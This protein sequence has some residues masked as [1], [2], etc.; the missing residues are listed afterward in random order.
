VLGAAAALASAPTQAQQWLTDV[1]AGVLSNSNLGNAVAGPDVHADTALTAALSTGPFFELRPGTNLI[2]TAETGAQSFGRYT[3]FSNLSA[4][5][6]AVLDTKF[7]LGRETP[8]VYLV[9]SDSRL[10]FRDSLRSGWLQ[11]WAGGAHAAF[12]D[13]LVLRGEFGVE[14]RT[15]PEAPAVRAGLPGDVFN[16]SSRRLA[17][18]ADYSLTDRL[19]LQLQTTLRRG[20]ADY[21]ETTSL[22]DT[23]DGASAVAR[24]PA[25]GPN[26]FIEKVQARELLLDVGVSWALG[27]HSSL[28]AMFRRELTLDSGATLYT[29]SIPAI[30]YEYRFD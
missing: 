9:G 15:G 30:I 1:Q 23:F 17:I 7:G 27:D 8:H 25:L 16:Q 4:G 2:V 13:R 20:D 12:G 29:R 18:G 19:L 5:I 26:I 6:K 3:A 11:S 21:I 24:E 10:D 22:A 28:N 14:R